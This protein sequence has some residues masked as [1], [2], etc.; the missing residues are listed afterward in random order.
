MNHNFFMARAIGAV[1]II[2]G[3][4]VGT[5]PT[6]ASTLNFSLV[7]ATDNSFVGTSFDATTGTYFRTSF[8]EPA[9][10]TAFSDVT[11]FESDTCGSA[12]VLAGD[13]QVGTN[14]TVRGGYIYGHIALGGDP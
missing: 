2:T 11:A 10:F 13:I 4:L 3:M 5:A 12:L 9:T 8:F 1:V 6:L 14:F 7:G